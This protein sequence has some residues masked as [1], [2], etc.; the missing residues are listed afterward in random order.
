MDLLS[1]NFLILLLVTF[2]SYYVLPKKLQWICLLA[3]SLTFYFF[4]GKF[5]FVFILLSSL[6]TFFLAKVLGI[7]NQDFTDK[8]E[9]GLLS[10]DELK[11]YKLKIRN[12]KRVI[13]VIT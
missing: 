9:E 8:T 10:K 3:A 11:E 4:A 5:N 12:K 13:L 7:Y 6:S 1:F 2:I